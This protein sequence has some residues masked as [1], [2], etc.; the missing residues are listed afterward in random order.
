MGFGRFSEDTAR[1]IR[2]IQTRCNGYFRDVFHHCFA[3]DL[4]SFDNENHRDEVFIS[5][6]KIFFHKFEILTTNQA[7][8]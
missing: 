6:L 4:I 3:L 8:K 5:N 7:N 2:F 1:Y